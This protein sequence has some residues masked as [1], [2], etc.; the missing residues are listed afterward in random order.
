MTK[1]V[2]T[3]NFGTTPR[4][5]I[6]RSSFD[7]SHGYKTTFDAGYLIPFYADEALPGDTFNLRTTAFARLGTPLTPFMDNVFMETFFFAVP[8]RQLWDNWEKFNGEQTDPTD[9]IDFT[10]PTLSWSNSGVES[11]S[12]YLGLPVNPAATTTVS[13]LFH[14][15]YT[16]IYNNWFRDQN[17]IDSAVLDTGDGPDTPASHPLQRRRKR[18]DYFTSC[19]PWPQ[20]G[21]PVTVSLGDTAPI[22]GLGIDAVQAGDVSSPSLRET[23]GGTVTYPQSISVNEL[24]SSALYAKVDQTT[25]PLIPEIYADLSAAAGISINDLRQSFQIQKLMERDARGGTRYPEILKS[26]FGVIDPQMLVLQRPEFLGGGST[27]INVN[28]K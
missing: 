19:L 10:I 8:V 23:G 13:A 15:A 26:H 18:P 11:L 17:L 27:A 22:I 2:M 25:A 7:R 21:T 4:A 28:P 24:A 1:S 3:H 16:H 9:S 14:R 20:K 5:E 12:D 6:P